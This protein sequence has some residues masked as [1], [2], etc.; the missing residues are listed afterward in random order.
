MCLT[1]KLTYWNNDQTRQVECALPGSL[2]LKL[3][4]WQHKQHCQLLDSNQSWYFLYFR[5]VNAIS[6]YTSSGNLGIWTVRI[7]V[8]PDCAPPPKASST[9]YLSP[10]NDN[11]KY[12]AGKHWV[13]LPPTRRGGMGV[14]HFMDIELKKFQR[15]MAWLYNNLNVLNV[16]EPLSMLK[17]KCYVYFT[18]KHTK[19]STYNNVFEVL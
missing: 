8:S 2:N 5:H 10:L 3:Q 11:F 6:L 17:S 19:A 15:W 4:T 12:A 18:T 9:Y 7:Q 1:V 13:K 16:C 14:Y